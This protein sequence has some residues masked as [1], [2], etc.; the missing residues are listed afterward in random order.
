MRL[1]TIGFIGKTA[2]RF[3]QSAEPKTLVDVRLNNKSQLAGFT[4]PDE[5]RS[6]TAVRF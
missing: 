5:W 2:E 6:G 4:K 3:L 1:C